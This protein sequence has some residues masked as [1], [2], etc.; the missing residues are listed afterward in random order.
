MPFVAD[1]GRRFG[2]VLIIGAIGIG[3]FVFRDHLTGAA[4]DLQ[5]GD[6]F[7]QPTEAVDVITEV[8]HR[9]CS[10]PHD[11]E[12]IVVQDYPAAS[13]TAYPSDAAMEGF[14]VAH[15]VPAFNS[16]TGRV[17]DDEPE[18]YVGLYQPTEDV[19]REGDHEI[20]CFIYRYNGA[21]LTGSLS[22]AA[23]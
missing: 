13:D 10:D 6:C 17:Y 3:G 11:A 19:W 14:H 18:L 21:K 12:V 22:A 7:D 1:L 8:Q 16:Y 4:A 2:I 9:P 15:C 5:V 20:T 23:Q